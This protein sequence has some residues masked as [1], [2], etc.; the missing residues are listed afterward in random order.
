LEGGDRNKSI[1]N[2]CPWSTDFSVFLCPLSSYLPSTPFRLPPSPTYMVPLALPP[3][4]SLP[5]LL[6]LLFPLLH[7][8]LIHSGSVHTRTA[9]PA[10]CRISLLENRVESFPGPVPFVQE[11]N[12]IPGEFPAV[13]NVLTACPP[14]EVAPSVS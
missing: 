1:L 4:L 5:L 6:K 9:T 8:F 3:S 12:F 11:P 7:L 10:C 14:H 2:T 13:V